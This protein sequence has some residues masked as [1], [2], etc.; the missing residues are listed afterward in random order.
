VPVDSEPRVFVVDDDPAVLRAVERLLRA[1]GLVVES[2]TSPAFFLTRLPYEGPACV[3]LDMRMPELN[4]LQ[5]QGALESTGIQTI[6]L[7]GTS[8]VPTAAQALRKGAVDFLVKP[9]DEAVL[10][11]AISRALAVSADSRRQQRQEAEYKK[12]LARLTKR[13]RQVCDLVAA[14]MMNKQIA[15]ELGRSER[16]I[17]VHRARV[18]QKLEVDSVAALVWLLARLVKTSVS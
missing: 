18:M 9:V 13:E 14:G 2:F 4:G 8:D 1:S 5:V 3:V 7:S 15:Y 12:R 11:G 17:K 16:T 6:F 10:L